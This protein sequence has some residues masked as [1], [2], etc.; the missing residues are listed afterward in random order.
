MIV[1]VVAAIIRR[2]GRFLITRRPANVHLGGLWEFPGGKVEPHES[3]V[4]AL[5]REIHEEIDVK[6]KVSR[7]SLE[8]EHS[9]ETRSVRLYFFDCEILSGEP[10][11]LAVADLRWVLPSELDNFAFPEADQELIDLLKRER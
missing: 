11:A 7:P 9:Y 6:V 8:I 5:T 2:D 4:E 10:R 1:R 3:L